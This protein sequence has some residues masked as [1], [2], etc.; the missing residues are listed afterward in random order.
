MLEE[1]M[2]PFDEPIVRGSRSALIFYGQYYFLQIS[3]EN[4]G[5]VAMTLG[6][7]GYTPPAIAGLHIGSN[8][9][10]RGHEPVQRMDFKEPPVL[11][12]NPP[13]PFYY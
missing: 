2:F 12:R 10:R 6:D 3:Q 13:Q 9:L 5:Q 1:E 11:I 7:H 8:L 4:V